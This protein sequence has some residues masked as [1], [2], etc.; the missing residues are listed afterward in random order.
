MIGP[1]HLTH[2]SAQVIMFGWLSTNWQS[3]A[4]SALHA[5]ITPAG[6]DVTDARSNLNDFPFERC[7]TDLGFTRVQTA[8]SDLICE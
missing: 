1:E 4:H 3:A 6:F 8:L 2:K 5:V 7:L